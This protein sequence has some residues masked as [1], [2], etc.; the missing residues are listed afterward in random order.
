MTV[1]IKVVLDRHQMLLA[2]IAG[3]QR[4]VENICDGVKDAFGAE[5]GEN[6]FQISIE[7]SMAE[8]AFAMWANKFWSGKGVMKGP[9]VNGMEIKSTR[10]RKDA[11]LIVHPSRLKEDQ[12]YWLVCGHSGTY[13]IVGW[14][15]GH[16]IKRMPLQKLREDREPVYQV[17]FK[18]LK[19][20]NEYKESVQAVPHR[21]KAEGGRCGNEVPR[22]HGG[23]D[24]R[25]QPQ[26]R[27][28]RHAVAIADDVQQPNPV[29]GE[30]QIPEP[31][32]GGM[33][34]FIDCRVQG[35]A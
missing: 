30:W 14:I 35:R 6:G 19:T 12:I 10:Y 28:E 11:K 22:R 15:W 9:D 1:M 24:L 3:L 8:Y 17:H 4:S 25:T 5:K 20:P 26:S 7:G 32:P 31:F 21:G 18:H 13:V 34:G 27:P 16:E 23:D 2:G 29:A 33:E